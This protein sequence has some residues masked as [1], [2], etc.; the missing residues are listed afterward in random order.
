M[1]DPIG[2]FWL[3]LLLILA[4]FSSGNIQSDNRNELAITPG[5]YSFGENNALEWC[6]YLQ[7]SPAPK[8]LM[9]NRIP[10]TGSTTMQTLFDTICTQNGK[11]PPH[12]MVTLNLIPI[13]K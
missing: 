4:T 13:L 1:R 7:Q 8:I 10:K 9:Y 12:H 3:C 11:C 6:N 5:L 2:S